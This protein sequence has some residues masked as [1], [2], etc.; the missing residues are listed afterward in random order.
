MA[1]EPENQ[2]AEDGEN[3]VTTVGAS[4]RKTL[5]A[6]SAVVAFCLVSSVTVGVVAFPDGDTESA[7]VEEVPA[8]KIVLP[9][10][11]VLVNL[12][13]SDTSALLQTTLSVELE[14]RGGGDAQSEFSELL[15]RVQDQLLKVLSSF[16]ASDIDGGASMSFV[17]T[18]I[19][20]RLNEELFKGEDTKVTNIFFTE[21]VIE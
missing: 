12:Q 20:D 5:I 4:R 18:R 2:Q 3:V 1:D 6:Y 10:P 14:T 8:K 11:Q 13:D 9:V 17:Q 19:I 15:P 7:V 21:F 16:S